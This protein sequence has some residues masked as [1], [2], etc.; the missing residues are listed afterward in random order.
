[1]FARWPGYGQ[2]SSITD[3]GAWDDHGDVQVTARCQPP[4]HC[5]SD[6]LERRN[7][8]NGG[9]S[10]QTKTL[11]AG[12]AW[13]RWWARSEYGSWAVWRTEVPQQ[14]RLVGA[15]LVR[16]QVSRR[17]RWGS[18]TFDGILELAELDGLVGRA[19]AAGRSR[20]PVT[21]VQRR[22]NEVTYADAGVHVP[23]GAPRSTWSTRSHGQQ[24][25][26]C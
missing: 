23:K 19:P 9:F 11:H 7:C 25:S 13:R 4:D 5:C 10:R 2:R 3:S 22:A 14:H 15:V 1:M 21:D 17:N 18:R 12:S 8:W 20:E 6:A 24:R 16:N 26:W